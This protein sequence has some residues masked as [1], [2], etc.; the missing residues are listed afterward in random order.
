[1]SSAYLS[2]LTLLTFTLIAFVEI[3]NSRG[4]STK[5]CGAPVFKT[6]RLNKCRSW[7]LSEGGQLKKHLIQWSCPPFTFVIISHLKELQIDTV[8][9]A[10]LQL[11]LQ[12]WHAGDVRVHSTTRLHS[13]MSVGSGH[14]W[15][16]SVFVAMAV[17]T[18]WMCRPLLWL[19]LC[20]AQW[21]GWVVELMTGL[22]MYP[23]LLSYPKWLV[24]WGSGRLQI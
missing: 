5:P 17:T 10:P 19:H 6:A 11:P 7:K 15:G 12:G 23:A 20:W 1:M 9:T 2:N 24:R 3:E 22:E 14:L 4:D 8:I 16:H 13:W 21:G 18:S